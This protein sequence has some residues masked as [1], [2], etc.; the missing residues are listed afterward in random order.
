LIVITPTLHPPLHLPFIL[1]HEGQVN[2]V[3]PPI[4]HE[5]V[6]LIHRFPKIYLR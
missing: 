4:L 1:F 3:L 2:V 5:E 6:D